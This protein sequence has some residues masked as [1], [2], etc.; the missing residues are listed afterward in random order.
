MPLPKSINFTVLYKNDHF[1]RYQKI[2]SSTSYTGHGPECH[3]P[4]F[5]KR[6]ECLDTERLTVK[7]ERCE[8]C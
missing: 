1:A 3:W 2:V 7:D 8:G 5:E 6:K 4:S